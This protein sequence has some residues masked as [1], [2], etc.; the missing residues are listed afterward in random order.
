MR[1]DGIDCCMVR[2][3]HTSGLLLLL[4]AGALLTFRIAV[5][6]AI[7][8]PVPFTSQA[9]TAQWSDRTY[10]DGCEEASMLMAHHWATRRPLS[11]KV[12]VR[13]IKAITAYEEKKFGRYVADTSA[14]DTARIMKSYFHMSG[15]SVRYRITERDIIAELRKGRIL[16]VPANGRLLNNPNY[17]QPGPLHHMLIIRGY[18]DA[19]GEFITNDPGTRRGEKYRYRRSVLV[20]AIRDYPTGNH[21][22]TRSNVKAMIVVE[23]QKL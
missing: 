14:D 5:A 1:A 4:A 17:K 22:P 12:A 23:R 16:I 2:L 21:A 10:E 9:P 11:K 3:N 15:V 8:Q 20:N 18:D 7:V 19:T 6:R 13:Q